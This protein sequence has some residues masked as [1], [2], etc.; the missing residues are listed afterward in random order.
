[1]FRHPPQYLGQLWIIETTLSHSREVDRTELGYRS[2]SLVVV[3]GRGVEFRAPVRVTPHPGEP[4]HNRVK[5]LRAALC[6]GAKPAAGGL[7]HR[8]RRARSYSSKNLV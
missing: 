6:A 1:V 5:W 8:T 7:R 3:R 2:L 4:N